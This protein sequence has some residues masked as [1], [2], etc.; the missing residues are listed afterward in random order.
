MF[1]LKN[2][3]LNGWMEVMENEERVMRFKVKSFEDLD[4]W[5]VKGI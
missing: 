1:F 2:Y 4:N 3:E 5:N